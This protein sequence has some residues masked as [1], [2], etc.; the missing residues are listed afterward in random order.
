MLPYENLVN[1][2]CD[3]F[4]RDW[5]SGCMRDEV[6]IHR[7]YIHLNHERKSRLYYQIIHVKTHQ[8]LNGVPNHSLKHA[9]SK[10]FEKKVVY[11]T[12]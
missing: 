7:N 1:D 3:G 10:D 11:R 4:G 6:G 2:I 5:R 8:K 9:R 12:Q